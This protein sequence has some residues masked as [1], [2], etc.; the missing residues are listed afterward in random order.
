MGNLLLC[1]VNFIFIAILYPLRGK[2]YKYKSFS[3]S[4]GLYA[5]L[6]I[7]IFFSAVLSYPRV[8]GI[9]FG[10]DLSTI[11][12]ATN[13]ALLLCKKPR[14]SFLSAIHIIILLWVIVGGDR[15]DSLASLMFMFLFGKEGK[16]NIENIN[17]KYVYLGGGVLF[18]LSIISGLVRDNNPVTIESFLFSIYAQQTV[19]DV[20]FVFL[21]SIEYNL[22]NG[23]YPDV[24]G[25][26]LFGL[27]PGPYYGVVSPYNFT[28][29]LKSFIPNPGGGLFYSEGMLAFGWFGVII[30]ITLYAL[31]IRFLFQRKERFFVT[32]FLLMTAMSFRIQWY[33]FIYCYKPVI[34]SLLYYCYF[35]VQLYEKKKFRILHKNIINATHNSTK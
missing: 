31:L 27:F 21:S 5:F 23:S 1:A 7:V 28:S 34:F 22:T 11:Y 30:Y 12:I 33:G 26:L 20:L 8:S 17:L 6:L 24:L 14:K 19:S 15:V 3:C 29:V 10:K 16:W 2:V 13:I 18:A 9:N 25:N 4:F 32:L 35:C